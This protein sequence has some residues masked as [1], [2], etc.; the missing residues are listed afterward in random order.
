M[1]EPVVAL[2]AHHRIPWVFFAIKWL[3]DGPDFLNFA[4]HGETS[5]AVDADVVRLRINSAH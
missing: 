1:G 4:P 3:S 5:R 2:G